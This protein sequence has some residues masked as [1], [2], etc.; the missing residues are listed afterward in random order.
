MTNTPVDFDGDG[1]RDLVRSVPDVLAS[2]ANYLKSHGWQRDQGWGPGQPNFDGSGERH[3]AE[4][5][6]EDHRAVNAD[7]LGWP[8]RRPKARRIGAV[9][10]Q[11]RVALTL[12]ASC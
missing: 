10:R 12:N 1:R 7:K 9:A 5:Y 2:T 11:T 8:R 3:Q 6:A 4:V